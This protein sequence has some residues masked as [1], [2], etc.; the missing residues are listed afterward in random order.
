MRLAERSEAGE[1]FADVYQEQIAP[2]W[3]YVRS[4]IWSYHDAQDVTAEVFARAW[5]SWPNY[6][7]RRGAAAPWIFR[8]AQRTVTDWLRRRHGD[9]LPR[10]DVS[11]LDRSAVASISERIETALL[12]QEV[13]TRLGWAGSSATTSAT[14]SRFGSP[15]A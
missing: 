1:D 3:R 11:S 10:P 15:A 13:L 5:R 8:I 7:P 4:R 2:V 14:A 9:E 12:D 6:N